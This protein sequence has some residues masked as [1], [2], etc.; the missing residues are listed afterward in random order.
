MNAAQRA[1]GA[2]VLDHLI[3]HP[4]LHNQNHFGVRNDDCGTTACVAGWTV[5]LA[6]PQGVTV[7][8]VRRHSLPELVM[9]SV[10]IPW[11]EQRFPVDEAAGLLL[12]LD[13]DEG[14]ELFYE[15]STEAEARAY[16]R[17]LL[18]AASV[19]A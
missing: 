6:A 11:L 18:D 17:Q 12:G 9:S 19:P 15:Y 5:L 4:E 8:W 3:H 2:I 14:Y 10:N 7:E 16:L 13:Y 1:L